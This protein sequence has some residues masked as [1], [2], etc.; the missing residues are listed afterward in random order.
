MSRIFFFLFG[1]GLMT[2]GFVYIILYLNILSIGYNFSYYVNFIS[3]RI[4]CY[5]SI[6]G[7]TFKQK[8][9]MYTW[10]GNSPS[11]VFI[12]LLVIFSLTLVF[13]SVF[14]VLTIFKNYKVNEKYFWYVRIISY[15]LTFFLVLFLVDFVVLD[16]VSRYELVE[17]PNSDTS[18][19]D[20]IIYFA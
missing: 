16:F 10:M 15:V 12:I 14:Y 3:R 19:Y 6:I 2:I 20:I 13:G 9:Q 1:F 7:L 11:F 5:F 18:T 8:E 4:E 17:K